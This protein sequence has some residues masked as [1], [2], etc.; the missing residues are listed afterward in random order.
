MYDFWYPC[1]CAEKPLVAKQS[2]I[3]FISSSVIIL[4]SH[5]SCKNGITQI[6][7]HDYSWQHRK[8]KKKTCKTSFSESAVNLF[9]MLYKH[10]FTILDI[11]TYKLG[12]FAV[13]LKKLID[14]DF[15]HAWIGGEW[16]R[17]LILRPIMH[18]VSAN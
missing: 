5:H 8:K 9:Q 11:M 6:S 18:P 7:S 12:L 15:K 10:L 13:A 4:D 2:D 16:K 17:S 1:L 3:I 14:L